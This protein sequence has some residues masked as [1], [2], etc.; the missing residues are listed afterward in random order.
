M[1]GGVL[2]MFAGGVSEIFSFGGTSAV[3]IPLIAASGSVAIV[4]ASGA[5]RA[6][7]NMFQFEGSWN[8][9]KDGKT[10]IPTGLTHKP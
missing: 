10:Q 5:I 1:G 7:R 3:S 6:L 9:S 4:S 8:E 2:G